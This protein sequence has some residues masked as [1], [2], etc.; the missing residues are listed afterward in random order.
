MDSLQFHIA[1][2]HHRAPKVLNKQ[3]FFFSPIRCGSDK[4]KTNEDKEPKLPE[5][6]RKV[7][8]FPPTGSTLVTP[9]VFGHFTDASA[10]VA[11]TC[12]RTSNLRLPYGWFSLGLELIFIKGLQSRSSRVGTDH[13]SGLVATPPHTRTNQEVANSSP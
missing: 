10:R 3:S 2:N 13:V 1:L 12:R 11:T 7:S 8:N 6:G 4:S 9:R 5:T